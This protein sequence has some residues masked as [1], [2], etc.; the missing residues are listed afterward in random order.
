MLLPSKMCHL[1]AK[2]TSHTQFMRTTLLKHDMHHF[3]SCMH[4]VQVH[5]AIV[6]EQNSLPTPWCH[7]CIWSG[8]EM[9]GFPPGNKWRVGAGSNT[10]EVA[11]RS[12]THGAVG[13]M[14]NH[15][16][17]DSTCM[18]R[19]FNKEKKRHVPYIH[20]IHWSNTP[21]TLAKNVGPRYPNNTPFHALVL[22]EAPNACAL[23]H[24]SISLTSPKGY[25]HW[26]NKPNKQFKAHTHQIILQANIH[27]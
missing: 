9:R 1:H 14:L 2:S 23:D 17:D 21:R 25:G 11:G 6:D 22:F 4:I 26:R 15:S 13:F 12:A 16:L 3:Y 5:G 27:K 19:N 18:Q 8:G 10:A 7:V 20:G 24:I